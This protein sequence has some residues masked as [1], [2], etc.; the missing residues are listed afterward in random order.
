MVPEKDDPRYAE[1][2]A[3]LVDIENR[4]KKARAGK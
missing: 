2:N 3:K 4:I 1:A